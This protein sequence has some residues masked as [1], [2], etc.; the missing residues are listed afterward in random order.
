MGEDANKDAGAPPTKTA[1]PAMLQS[2]N[3]VCSH[4]TVTE[5][6]RKLDPAKNEQGGAEA[7]VFA[8]AD[9]CEYLVKAT[10]NPQDGKIV[11]NDLIGGLA[12]AWLG[13]LH[14]PT[15]IVDVPQ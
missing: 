3:V 13:V 12:L 14:P 2:Q 11:V 4:V 9:G 10:N 1:E 6:R 5:W 15:V 8:D 7:Q